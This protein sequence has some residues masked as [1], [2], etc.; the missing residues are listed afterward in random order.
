MN[1]SLT[2]WILSHKSVVA[3]FWIALTFAGFF[4]SSQVTDALDE[5][6]SMP[7]SSAYAVSQEIEQRFDSGGAAPPLVAVANLPAGADAREPGVRAD[8]RQLERRLAA[9]MPGARIASYGSTGERAFVS[10]D[11]RTTF[12]IAYPRLEEGGGPDPEVSP[13]TVEA[14]RRAVAGAEVGGS[15]VLLTGRAALEDEPADEVEEPSF[16]SETLVA[17]LAA[18][19]VLV[20][21]FA[22]A[23][24]VVPLLM[25]AVAIPVTLLA[26]LGLTALTDVSFIVIFLCSLIGLGLAIDY[27]LIVVMRWREE[28]DRG[29][30]NEEA[31]ALAVRTAGRAVLFSGTT[32]AIGLLAA[33]VLPIPFLRS[34]AYGGL[35]IPLV[36][37]AVALTLLPVVLAKVG[38][39]A[40]RHRLRRAERAE[41]HW[42]AWARLV[43][44]H[45]VVAVAASVAILAGLAGVAGGILLGEPE[46]ASLGGKGDAEAGLVALERSGIG[47][48]PLTPVEVIAPAGEAPGA[49]RALAEVEGVRA[50]TAPGG[51]AWREGGR[52]VLDVFA[53]TDTASTEGRDTVAAV[54]EAAAELPGVGVGGSTALIED[55]VDDVYGS[56]PLMLGLIAL[57]TFALL[58]RAFR[59]IVLPLKAVAMNLLSVFAT[60]GVM[61]LVWQHG[62]GTE[63]LFGTEAVGSVA[64]WSPM[65]V[66]AFIYGLSM[67]YEVFIL[68][69][70]REEYE[71]TGSTDEAVVRGIASTG[72]LVTSAALIVFLAFA[73]MATA[74]EID[75]KVLAT[76]LGAGVLLDALVVRSLLVPATVSWLGR[77]NWWM[78]EPVRRLL[79]LPE[80][81]PGP[82]AGTGGR[83]RLEQTSESNEE[84]RDGNATRIPDR[85]GGDA[86]ARQLERRRRARLDLRLRLLDR[87]DRGGDHAAPRPRLVQARRPGCASSRERRPDPRAPLR[88]R[89][90]QRRGVPR[91]PRRAR[92][93]WEGGVG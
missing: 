32:V 81:R 65:I 18:L 58:V 78:P 48:A 76:G 73:S 21:V 74:E 68:A 25:A 92:R 87:A 8:L 88:R 7:S 56:F 53:A 2:R 79:R 62:F 5:Q 28:R 69:R 12:A 59:S 4:G 10:D 15:Q 50:A 63:L 77:W 91:A 6:F 3:I 80:P 36:S 33:V 57:I 55:W 90:A 30:G 40:D 37:V 61:T 27:A 31:I 22:S 93:G 16:L 1:E 17:G 14:A 9:A 23:L 20:F 86:P 75:V 84:E 44:R 46:A 51:D 38:P 54:R 64:F 60:W 47:A 45:R 24:A 71:R 66:F 39:W 82:A 49:A 26:V 13:E 19:V 43:T 35:L 67:D 83:A 70:I 11:G 41:R 72:R 85:A 42:S 89:A 34:M 29:A 52:A